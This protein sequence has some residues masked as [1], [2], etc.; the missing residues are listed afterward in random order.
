M[1]DTRRYHQRAGFDSDPS[2][3]LDRVPAGICRRMR[4]PV[5]ERVKADA[6]ADGVQ[7]AEGKCNAQPNLLGQR[8]VQ[9]PDYRQRDAEQDQVRQD[10][11]E[12]DVGQVPL[13]IHAVGCEAGGWV[14]AG[15]DPGPG[16]ADDEGREE[17]CQSQSE[18]DAGYEAGCVANPGRMCEDA[19]VEAAYGELRE[20][21]GSAIAEDMVCKVHLS[22][23]VGCVWVLGCCRFDVEA[24]T[25]GGH[26]GDGED[27]DRESQDE[28][29]QDQI[30]VEAE[31]EALF[32][33]GEQTRGYGGQH[34]DD[35]DSGY[36]DDLV[37]PRVREMGVE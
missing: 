1:R 27:A 29:W 34:G 5:C 8:L 33:A 6:R 22:E 24:E 36:H 15:K 10:V 17:N 28:G 20:D 19:V 32:L 37:A 12:R 9:L 31:R 26:A 13:P 14:G 21:D 7:A 3:G 18:C 35:K 4:G 30:V 2:R 25:E 16:P 23:E 11:R